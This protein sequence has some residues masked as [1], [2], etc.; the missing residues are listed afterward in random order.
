VL[1][2]IIE[3]YGEVTLSIDVMAIKN[4]PF[5][6]TTIRNIHF[7]VAELI[8]NKTKQHN[9]DIHITSHLKI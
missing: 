6:F 9:F 7:D 2:E 1:K 5:I 8:H 3:N 4:I